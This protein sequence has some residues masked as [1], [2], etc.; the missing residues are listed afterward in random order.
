MTPVLGAITIPLLE[1]FN[2]DFT[3]VTMLTGYQ[4]CAVGASAFFISA[5]ARKFGKRPLMIASMSSVLA[6]AAWASAAESYNSFVGARV[7]QGLGIAMFESVT[8]DIVGDMYHVHQRGTRMSYFIFAQSGMTML[9]SVLAGKTAETLGWRGVWHVITGFLAAG[10]ALCLLFGWETAFRRRDVLDLDAD[11]SNKPCL[12]RQSLSRPSAAPD[13]KLCTQATD[14]VGLVND[15]KA[16][17]GKGAEVSLEVTESGERNVPREP[18]LQ[19]LRLF[20]GSFTDDSVWVMVVRPFF[21]LLNA[22]V[23]WTVI[24]TAFTSVWYIVTSFVIAQA[25]SGPPY[26]LTV[27]QQGYMSSGP[28]VGGI[29]GCLFAGLICDPIARR[30]TKKNKG[31][32]EPEFRLIVMAFVP[33]FS[34]IGYF[35]FGNL[36]AKGQSP[37]GVSATFPLDCAYYPSEFH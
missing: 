26:S 1:E 2:T 5:L 20:H 12:C 23:V 24:M 35:A 11:V 21:V 10:V 18:F 33:I 30:M 9:P 14:S 34:T 19:R 4:Q 6:G 3:G 31:I 22:T 27:A 36:I 37:V 29:L 17:D 15:E 28:W 7:V 13:R 25:F 32:Y 16:V 8:Y